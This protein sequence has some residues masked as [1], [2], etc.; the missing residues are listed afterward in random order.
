MPFA[1]GKLLRWNH[2]GRK[3]LG[4]LYALQHGARWVYDTDDDNELQSMAQ[5]IPLPRSNGFVDEVSTN[6]KLYNLYPQLSTVRAGR[7]HT[8]SRR[9]PPP[10]P[11]PSP[12]SRAVVV[13]AR[14]RRR[15]RFDRSRVIADTR[16]SHPPARLNPNASTSTRRC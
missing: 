9:P 5:G 6:H 15:R 11:A 7:A 1:T 4:F 3:N 16:V 12:P 13:A 2:F 14:R 10:P 8:T